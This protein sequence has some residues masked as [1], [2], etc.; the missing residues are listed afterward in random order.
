MKK[1]KPT[2]RHKRPKNI[3]LAWL[4]GWRKMNIE[5]I[6]SLLYVLLYST[7]QMGNNLNIFA[8]ILTCSLVLNN[9]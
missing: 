4:M 7:R 1:H 6:P 5:A 8:L 3:W 2:F 9:F